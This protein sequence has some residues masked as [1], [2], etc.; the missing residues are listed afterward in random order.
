MNAIELLTQDHKA[1]A[2]LLERIDKTTERAVKLR[3][4]FLIKL[5]T[6][7]QIHEEM[8]ETYFYPVLKKHKE[9]QDLVFEALEEHQVIDYLLKAIEK[10]DYDTKE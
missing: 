8:E 1:V 6:S 5:K 2:A 9:T 7:L 10:D 3:A 4:E